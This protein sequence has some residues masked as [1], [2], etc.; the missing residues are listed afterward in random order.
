MR[1][2]SVSRFKRPLRPLIDLILT[3]PDLTHTQLA[4]LSRCDA[5]RVRRYRRAIRMR[6]YGEDD[7]RRC[8]ERALQT[9]LKRPRPKRVEAQPDFDSL[10]AGLPGATGLAQWQS[11][12]D[13]ALKDG[14]HPLSYSWFIRC[15]RT[16]RDRSQRTD[17]QDPMATSCR[18]RQTHYASSPGSVQWDPRLQRFRTIEASVVPP[19]APAAGSSQIAREDLPARDHGPCT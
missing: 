10:A 7:L 19:A 1:Y 18:I 8:H 15:L 11:Y 13:A 3:N 4:R 5:R 16:H 6:A 17:P 2:P 9:L 14:K 12:R